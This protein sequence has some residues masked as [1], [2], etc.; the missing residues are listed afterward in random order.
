MFAALG[1]NISDMLMQAY[2]QDVFAY[3]DAMKKRRLA[4]LAET[5]SYG[6]MFL[7]EK[8]LLDRW[9]SRGQ[10]VSEPSEQ[11]MQQDQ[12]DAYG[13]MFLEGN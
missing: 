13:K 2:D 10:D 7:A 8:S 5:P 9:F 11:E 1:V 3:K 12:S 6:K 4:L